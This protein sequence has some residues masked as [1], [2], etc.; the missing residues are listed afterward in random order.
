M[1]DAKSLL[2]LIARGYAAGREDAATE[3]LCS[4]V[5]RSDSATRS[6]SEFL[7]DNGDPLPITSFGTQFFTAGAFPDMVC[8]DKDDKR[9]AFVESKFWAT[10][11]YHQPVTY[12]TKL[13]DDRPAV[14][15][16]VAPAARMARIDKGWMWHQLV[17]RLNRAGHDLVSVDRRESEGLLTA[18]S[19]DG[20]RRLMLTSWNVLLDSL[21]ERC[22]E[23]E[24]AQACFELAELRGLAVDAI[25]ND[26]PVR[27]A[28]LKRLIDNA[29][30]QLK[31]SGWANTVG[32]GASKLEGVYYVKF[33]RL[34]GAAAGLRIDYKAKKKMNKPLWLRFWNGSNPSLQVSGEEVR[35]R[36]G[37][38]AEPGLEWLPK[39]ICV[40]ID[41][42]A[43]ADCESTLKAIVAKLE[44]IA[45]TIDPNGPTYPR[46]PTTG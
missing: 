40:P 4:I 35:A 24:D 11:T 46:N 36:L 30:T 42:P 33:F 6:L 26:D 8:F 9:V 13:A 44:C 16:F 32:R 15:L 20:Q 28:N 12:W 10:L 7:G 45:E 39:D 18:M 14:L 2:S 38:L 41:L 37:P 31:E 22:K 21:V 43:G 1:A 17:D 3:A 34:A 29:V 27:D 23:D 19:E 5:S 25:K